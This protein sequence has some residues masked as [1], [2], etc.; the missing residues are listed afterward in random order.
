MVEA[1]RQAYGLP[2]W[3]KKFN[4]FV[5]KGKVGAADVV[6]L[7][8]QTYMNLSGQSVQPALAFYKL[9]PAS[10]LVVHDE[11]D[12]PLGELKYKMGGGDAGHNGL[13]SITGQLGSPAY[14]RLRVGV[15]RPNHK[16]QVADYVLGAFAGAEWDVLDPLVRWVTENTER[17]LVAP[18]PALAGRKTAPAPAA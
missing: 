15:G 9:P 18:V 14:G 17:L 10:L 4:G 2:A 8:P 1:V 11:I 6:L 7:M 5:S 12:L 16:G 3:S 13:K